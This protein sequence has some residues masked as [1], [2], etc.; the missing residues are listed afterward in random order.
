MAM[1]RMPPPISRVQ[2][3][4]RAMPIQASS[5][6]HCRPRHHLQRVSCHRCRELAAG[7]PVHVNLGGQERQREQ[8]GDDRQPA[9]LRLTRHQVRAEPPVQPRQCIARRHHED[10]CQP[11][12]H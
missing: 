3:S 5:V 8:V 1:A 4:S 9:N 12:A 11:P 7:L 2:I 6:P 10:A